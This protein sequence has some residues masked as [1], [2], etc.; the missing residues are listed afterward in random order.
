MKRLG[1][2]T[3]ILWIIYCKCDLL[4]F[5][6]KVEF[7]SQNSRVNKW[8]ILVKWERCG[9]TVYLILQNFQHWWFWNWLRLSYGIQ[10]E[11]CMVSQE[12]QTSSLSH[13]PCQVYQLLVLSSVNIS[14]SLWILVSNTCSLY[15]CFFLFKIR[16]VLQ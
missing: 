9:D 15:N 12:C 1:R 5:S 8:M 13:T 2:N 14:S 7:E 6:Y 3:L 4:I 16:V 11:V 10:N